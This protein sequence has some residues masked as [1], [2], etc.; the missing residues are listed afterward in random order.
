MAWIRSGARCALADVRVET[1]ADHHVVE[2]E[3]CL[4]GLDPKAVRVELYADGHQ[5]R[6]SGTAGNEAGPSAAR[7]AV[8][9]TSIA[10]RYPCTPS[11]RLHSAS[12]TAALRGGSAAGVRPNP[13]ATVTDKRPAT[14]VASSI[15]S[16]ISERADVRAGSPSARWEP[17]KGQEGSISLF[18]A[19]TP[20]AFGWSCSIIPKTQG[21]PGS[22]IWIRR[23]IEPATSGTSGSAGLHPVNSMHIAWTDPTS[24]AKASLQFQPAS[25][26]S[27][28]Y[29]DLAAAADGIS[30]RH[31]D[32]TASAPS[33]I[34]LSTQ[35]NAASMPK[36]VCVDEP[37]D[38]RGDHPPRHPWSQTIIYETHVRGFTIHPKSGVEHPGTYRGLIEKIPYLKELGVTAVELMPVQE[39]NETLCHARESAGRV[40]PLKITGATI[41]WCS[42][43]P[44]RP[45]A[46]REA[47]GQQK[48][49]FKEMVRAFHQA[50]IEV[51]LD[52]VFNHTAEGD[53]L[54]SDPL[55]SRDR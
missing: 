53:E 55:L 29:G 13:M 21:R 31:G 43:R 9:A 23:A 41:R 35:D 40:S 6:R 16:E 38:W 14:R 4:N 18:S 30:R 5:R 50:G 17:R 27:L 8:A 2:V 19:V 47:L 51:I 10:Q 34:G 25:P 3:L 37:F 33:K 49:E 1:D 7:L 48:L 52:V 54:G 44:R 22:S 28:R 20:A 12:D 42:V 32:T 45:T 36:C 11:E 24:P 46:A 26:G 39:F 15:S